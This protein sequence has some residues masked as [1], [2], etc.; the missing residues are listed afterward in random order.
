MQRYTRAVGLRALLYYL[1]FA[2]PLTYIIDQPLV[3]RAIRLSVLLGAV[4]LI[5]STVLARE[6]FRRFY[7]L[8]RYTRWLTVAIVVAILAAILTS[9]DSLETRLLGLVPEYLGGLTW[10]AFI[11]FGVTVARFSKTLMSTKVILPI[12]LIILLVSLLIN[13]FNL[14]YGLRVSGLLLQATSMAM[15]ACLTFAIG[16]KATRVQTQR[17]WRVC[18]FIVVALSLA[19]VILTQSRIGYIS[20]A[21][22]SV[23]S[24]WVGGQTHRFEVIIAVLSC[25]AVLVLPQFA[26]DYFSRF[27][28]TS[29]QKGV[30]YRLDLYEISG[31]D[32]LRN[33]LIMGNGPSSLPPA[34]NN[35]N[36]V[37]DDIQKSLQSGDVFLS[38]HDLYFDFAYYFGVAA[39]LCLLVLSTI[40]MVLYLR[41]KEY[42]MLACFGVLGI[43]A[44]FN[45]PSLELTSLYFVFIFAAFWAKGHYETSQRAL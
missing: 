21:L 3:S 7:E 24:V 4:A 19:V 40:A 22:L 36:E 23:G 13:R 6:M 28:I 42:F 30:E 5:L 35:R 14:H 31:R 11:I 18:S 12:S 45:T 39:G 44:L 33:N 25:L 37:P 26:Q 2:L 10:L 1:I 15:F 27:R 43:N 20:V 17:R 32:L 8:K 34:I 38:T 16:L 29:V 9:S 41:A